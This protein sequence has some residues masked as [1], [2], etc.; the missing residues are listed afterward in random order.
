M[1]RNTLANDPETM[2]RYALDGR[3]AMIWT[4]MPGIV[5]SVNWNEMTC[6]IQPAIQGVQTNPDDTETFVDLPQLVD[7]P[8]CFPSAGGFTLT[9]PMK[10]DDEVLVIIASR[11]I[12]AW[13]QSGGVQQPM[14]IRMHDLSDGFALPGPRSLPKVAL[15]TTPVNPNNAQLRNDAGTCYL[16]ITPAGKINLVAPAGVGIVGP[17]TVMGTIAATGE[18]VANT[19]TTP[20][21][22]SAHLHPGVTAGGADTGAPIP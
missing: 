14:E 18:V 6:V 10:P 21:P 16:E 19:A 11:C 5:Q 17:L 22:L 2:Q 1:D 15:L 12:D 8:I 9:L 20:I 7:C 3:Q 4:A 13:W